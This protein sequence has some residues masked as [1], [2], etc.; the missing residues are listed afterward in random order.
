MCR[1]SEYRRV[2][3]MGMAVVAMA[4]LVSIGADRHQIDVAITH[5]ALGNRAFSDFADSFSGA[6]EQDHLHAMAMVEPGAHGRDCQI[7]VL[8]LDALQPHGEIA[9]VKVIDI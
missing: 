5:A 4:V 8:M 2:M 7:M 6:P 9:P 3:F 1:R